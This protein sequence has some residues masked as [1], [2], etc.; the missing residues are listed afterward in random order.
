MTQ[1]NASILDRVKHIQHIENDTEVTTSYDLVDTCLHVDVANMKEDLSLEVVF[2]N[3]NN[4]VE[5]EFIFSAE[6][7]VILRNHLNHTCR[8]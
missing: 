7:V 3:A 4:Q 2:T 1:A 8:A 5:K 6:E